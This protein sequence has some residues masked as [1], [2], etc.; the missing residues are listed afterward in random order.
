VQARPAA[1]RAHPPENC[2]SRPT[3]LARLALQT[4]LAP[5]AAHA[6][7]P[8]HSTPEEAPTGHFQGAHGGLAEELLLLPGGV[9]EARRAPTPPRA[10]PSGPRTDPY[11][12][13]DPDPALDE[14]QPADRA[15]L[16]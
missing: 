13:A 2:T 16:E 4:R 15:A 1:G 9:A 5:A 6:A 12:L 8:A 11:H 10:V 7:I 3:P 14:A